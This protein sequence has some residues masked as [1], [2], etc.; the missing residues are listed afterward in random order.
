MHDTKTYWVSYCMEGEQCQ[1]FNMLSLLLTHLVFSI[2][3][4]I[5]ILQQFACR[6]I[7]VKHNFRKK[8]PQRISGF[9]TVAPWGSGYH[10]CITSFN[11]AWTQVLYRFKSCSWHVG[12]L[13]WRVSLTMVLAGN[14]TKLLL[15]FNP[16]TKQFIIINIIIIIQDFTGVA[17]FWPFWGHVALFFAE[18]MLKYVSLEIFA[19][20]I[21]VDCRW[22]C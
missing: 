16:T 14:K 9:L 20:F 12:D 7:F 1:I 22:L 4:K 8:T 3:I 21:G 13:W 18:T 10:Y 15:Q 6:I 2:C 11:K 17:R 5:K 19:R